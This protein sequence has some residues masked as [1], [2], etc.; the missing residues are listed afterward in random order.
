MKTIKPQPEGQTSENKS[1][2]SFNKMKKEISAML[3]AIPKGEVVSLFYGVND[4][5]TL[6]EPFK[7]LERSHNV[8]KIISF[9][10][11]NGIFEKK[12]D[13]QQIGYEIKLLDN[14]APAIFIHA[15]DYI[16]SIGNQKGYDGI[17]YRVGTSSMQITDSQYKEMLKVKNIRL[18]N[19][20]NTSY[21]PVDFA[22]LEK[23]LAEKGL[24]YSLVNFSRKASLVRTVKKDLKL[25]Y[26]GLLLKDDQDLSISI[27]GEI[28]KGPL[29][30]IF[31]ESVKKLN[32]F[33][34]NN[35]A[36]QL[37]GSTRRTI[38]Q[39]IGKDTPAV[40]RE[41]VSNLIIHSH[42]K[43]LIESPM[44][45]TMDDKGIKLTN[46]H[47]NPI[48]KNEYKKEGNV[49]FHNSHNPSIFNVMRM[50]DLSEG[51]GKGFDLFKKHSD[52]ID[53]EITNDKFILV[54]KG[55]E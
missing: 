2:F 46:Y 15:T 4:D 28:I 35:D 16:V 29:Y 33:A 9:L 26:L 50:L 52:K 45:I 22:L 43:T 21:N 32:D 36:L 49:L 44:D 8:D 34:S 54:V 10:N 5:L 41:A 18:L 7:E 19:P 39:I 40:I 1:G 12:D 20:T 31:E 55:I 17:F 47:A 51:K 38:Y 11:E 27:N 6:V 53:I 23:F 3:N 24:D 37:N 42:F 14:G 25:T 13:S 30:K 48:L